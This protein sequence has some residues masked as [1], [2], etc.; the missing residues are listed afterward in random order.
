MRISDWSSDVCSSDLLAYGVAVPIEAEPFEVG[1]RCRDIIFARTAAV[2]IV[3]ADAE[4]PARAARGNVRKH[5]AIGVA[6]VELAG[7]AGGETRQHG[8]SRIHMLWRVKDN[9][10]IS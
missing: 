5:R 1:E 4:K 10:S 3:D 6:E 2:D 9:H 8:A 7:R